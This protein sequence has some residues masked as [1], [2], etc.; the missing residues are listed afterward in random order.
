MRRGFFVSQ[1]WVRLTGTL[2]PMRIAVL[3]FNAAAGTRAALARQFAQFASEIARNITQEQVDAVNYMAQV[4]ENGIPKFAMVNPSE[5]LNETEMIKQFFE[6]PEVESLMDGLF[7]MDESGAGNF[8]VRFF[9]KGKEDSPEVHEFAFLPGAVL[10]AE[11]SVIAALV[12]R[13]G[14]QMPSEMTQDENLFGTSSAVAFIKFLEGFDASQYLERSQGNV[15]AEFSPEPAFQS[16]QEA[17]EADPDWE[18]PFLTLVQICRLCTNYRIGNAP[19]IEQTLIK[20]TETEAEDPRAWFALG[21]LY[22]Q[23][24]NNE[25]AIDAFEKSARLEPNEP[26]ILT[27]LGLSQMAMNMPVNAE[28]NFRKAVEMEGDEKPS[29]PMLA[30]VLGRQ[31]RGHEVP[32]LWK[33]LVDKDPGNGAVQAQYAISLLQTG[34]KDEAIRAFDNAL[35]KVEDNTI[36]KRYYAPVLSEEGDVDRAMDFYEDCLDIAPNDIPLMLEYAQ[37][38]QKANREFEIPSVLNNVL[39]SNPDPNTRAQ[40]QAWLIEIEQPKRVEAVRLASEKVEEGDVKTALAELKPLRNWLAD[41][42]K[43]WAILAAAHNRVEEY[44]EAETASRRLLEMFPACE[45]GYGELAT[46]L[47][48]QER[49]DEAFQLMQIAM[50]NMPNSLMIAINYALSA[51]RAGHAEEARVMAKQIRE[52]TNNQEDLR[53]L[54]DDLES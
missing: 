30:E 37:T 2:A 12:N 46:A 9:E 42:W 21:D 22:S 41:Y 17:I 19:L 44:Q 5:E 11:R 24:G 50:G 28:R 27:R 48:G 7:R 35:E 49:H 31:G 52:A 47:S 36:V 39:S 20:A 43:M 51:K 32:G 33:E 4:E 3:P 26:A 53:P 29:M 38:L 40:T 16:L 13:L 10:E 45:P 34:Q 54:L 15:S 14:H 23:I 1:S 6:Q 8:T 18:A 25:K